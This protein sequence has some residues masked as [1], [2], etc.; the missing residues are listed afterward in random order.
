MEDGGWN[1]EKIGLESSESKTFQSQGQV[2]GWRSFG[3]LKDEANEIE[4]PQVIIAH[5]FPKQFRSDGLPVVHAAL[6]RIFSDDSIDHDDFLARHKSAQEANSGRGPLPSSEPTVLPSEL[7]CCLS[8]AGRHKNER[9]NTD[10]ESQDTL[11]NLISA[12]ITF[13]K[14]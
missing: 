8:R 10:H 13:L 9:N 4:Q 12:V 6:F 1:D 2:L 14:K 5:R 11:R 7:A 3:D